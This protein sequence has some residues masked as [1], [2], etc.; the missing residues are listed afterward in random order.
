M[1]TLIGEIKSHINQARKVQEIFKTVPQLQKIGYND[2]CVEHEDGCTIVEHELIINNISLPG[3]SD[4]DDYEEY[5][6]ETGEGDELPD[7][8]TEEQ[9]TDIN[10]LLYTIAVA[11]DDDENITVTSEDF[12]LFFKELR[13][14]IS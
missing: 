12:D 3:Y 8:L 1:K 2:V 4:K 5:H 11:D 10:N 7:W 6:K 9:L 14:L 13:Q